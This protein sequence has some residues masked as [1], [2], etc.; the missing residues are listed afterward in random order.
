MPILE[1]RLKGQGH[2]DP[3]MV[4]DTSLSQDASVHQIWESYLK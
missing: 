4:C 3:R 1:T 2:S